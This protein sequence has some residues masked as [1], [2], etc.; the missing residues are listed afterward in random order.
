MN[1]E[2]RAVP[3]TDAEGRPLDA[4]CIRGLEVR[5]IV[6]V[7][8]GERETP[9]PLRID[10][11]VFLDTRAAGGGGGIRATVDYGRLTGEL[12]FILESCRFQLL[13]T[14]ADALCHYLLAPP[15]PDQGRAQ[16]EA[17]TLV[18]SKPEA[19]GGGTVASLE[20]HR[21]KDEVAV[22]QEQKQ[23]G[24]VDIVHQTRDYGL[25]RLR[26][27]PGCS[28]PTHVHQVMEEAEMV[29]GSKL[30]LQSQPVRAGTV[31]HWPHGLP[32][33]YDNPSD[34]EQTILCVDRPPFIPSD[35]VE[36]GEPEGG[37]TRV[38]GPSFYPRGE[39]PE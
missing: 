30:Q 16:I 8:S 34:Q 29:L 39:T 1:A 37:L 9:Q 23:F 21:R 4:I 17:V 32:H 18:V 26:V 20:V 7:Y 36:V 31:L 33:R 38:E 10:L 11:Q 19:L 2:P 24:T 5:C 13:E 22:T 27:A 28:I 35:E 3:P 6:G 12:R 25:Y 14:A 15:T